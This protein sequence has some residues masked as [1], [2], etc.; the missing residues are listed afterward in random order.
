MDLGKIQYIELCFRSSINNNQI[1]VDVDYGQRVSWSNRRR[2]RILR[3]KEG[4]EILF[5]SNAE[6][7]NFFYDLGFELQQVITPNCDS[8]GPERYLMKRRTAN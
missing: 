7:Y 4:E 2:E 5:N 6:I 1:K 3:N 8:G